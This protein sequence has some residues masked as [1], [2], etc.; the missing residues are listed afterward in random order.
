MTIVD[1]IKSLAPISDVAARYAEVKRRGRLSVCRCLCGQNTDRN[2]SFTLYDDDNHFHCYACGRHGS[3]IDLV[4]LA[5]GLDFRAAV[6][7][8]Q[9]DYLL[10]QPG[11]AS[12]GASPAPLLHTTTSLNQCAPKCW[13][14]WKLPRSTTTPRSCVRRMP[15]PTRAGAA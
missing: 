7:Q 11:D 6:E 14:C 2:P 8:L 5:E 13:L 12:R 3:V 15:C 4:M 1:D 9:R 10:H